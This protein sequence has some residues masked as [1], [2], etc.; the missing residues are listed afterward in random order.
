[1]KEL[2]RNLF[3]MRS[4][5]LMLMQSGAREIWRISP[6]LSLTDVMACAENC[7]AQAACSKGEEAQRFTDDVGRGGAARK[8]TKRWRSLSQKSYTRAETACTSGRWSYL[9]YQ[10]SSLGAHL[11][12]SL[13]GRLVL[14]AQFMKP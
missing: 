4:P 9:T 1:M 3:A 2:S 7:P 8:L 13:S 6:P 5:E 12:H 10:V 14:S 11:T